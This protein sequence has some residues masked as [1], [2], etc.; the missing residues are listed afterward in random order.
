MGTWFWW[1]LTIGFSAYFVLLLLDYNRPFQRLSEQLEDLQL[2][3]QKL[4]QRLE[5]VRTNA[6]ELGAKLDVLELDIMGLEERRQ[7]LLPAIN[8]RTMIAITAGSFIM[9]NRN[10][11]SPR[12]ERPAHPVFLSPFLISRYPITNAEYRDFVQCTN[13]KLPGHWQL[14]SYPNGLAQHPVVNV[15]WQDARAFAS[16]RG[17]RLPTEA[18]W[19]KAA[20]GTDERH[21]PWGDRYFDEARCNGSNKI[22]TTTPVDTFPEGRSPYGVWDL[23]GNVYEWCFDYYEE[24]YYKTA[25][26][27]NPKGPEKGRDRVVRGGC[28]ADTRL[29][30]QITHRI[31]VDEVATRENI[32]FRIAVDANE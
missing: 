12:N 18:E 21:Y 16:W 11:D 7:E 30:L 27:A 24:N 17:A 4:E 20:R 19:E 3:G 10:E 22:G 9:G 8:A 28:F 26:T 25:P 14:G 2:R 13:R 5:R 1:A 32:G 15:S 23:C 31:G 6:F 29:A